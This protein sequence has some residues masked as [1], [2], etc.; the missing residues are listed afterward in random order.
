MYKVNILILIVSCLLYSCNS[1]SKDKLEEINQEIELD[2]LIVND[3]INSSS[4]PTEL[5]LEY[6]NPQNSFESLIQIYNG[7]NEPNRQLVAKYEIG[8]DIVLNYGN[9][10]W[11]LISKRA[12]NNYYDPSYKIHFI[13]TIGN[14]MAREYSDFDIIDYNIL[15]ETSDLVSVFKAEYNDEQIGLRKFIVV[16]SKIDNDFFN[17]IF[18]ITCSARANCSIKQLFICDDFPVAKTNTEFN[19][20]FPLYMSAK[21]KCDS[22][23][24]QFNVMHYETNNITVLHYVDTLNKRSVNKTFE[25]TSFYNG[26]NV[27]YNIDNFYTIGKEIKTEFCFENVFFRKLDGITQICF[28]RKYAWWNCEDENISHIER[29]D[30]PKESTIMSVFAYAKKDYIVVISK[31]AKGKY[32]TSLFWETCGNRYC[33]ME[34]VIYDNHNVLFKDVKTYEDF[35]EIYPKICKHNDLVINYK[36]YN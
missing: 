17:N 16:I 8:K 13:S 31:T 6:N 26:D 1:N 27:F 7:Y 14:K 11:I 35:I 28:T 3:E 33:S 5:F 34:Q 24:I 23:E 22:S 20:V 10:E 25:G 2:S 30:L 19:E 36:P 9:L 15:G 29:F 12:D 18:E 4:F 21:Q 32:Q